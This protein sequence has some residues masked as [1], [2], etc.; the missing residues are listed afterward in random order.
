MLVP[1]AIQEGFVA[2]TN[3]VQGPTI[4]LEEG[5]H[6]TA[7][8]TYPEYACAG[9]TEAKARETHDLVT[10]V[11]PFRLDHPHNHRWAH[12]RVLQARCRSQ[13]RE[14]IGLP[15]CGR[16]SGG[17]CPSGGASDFDWDAGGRPGS[18]PACV[19]DLHGKPRLCG[20]GRGAAARPGRGLGSERD[21]TCSFG[22]CL[23][24]WR[25]APCH[26][27]F[28]RSSGKAVLAD[29]RGGR[30]RLELRQVIAHRKV[31]ARLGFR[32]REDRP[33]TSAG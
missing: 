3:A 30:W 6:T 18:G 31:C 28:I 21:R 25:G 5:V 17:D 12:G 13:D 8:F 10:A 1:P 11:V 2:A 15:R 22:P 27:R 4:R 7:G 23:A 26:A 16:T 20:S 32:Q 9:V 29:E 24:A 14:D 33:L 19:S